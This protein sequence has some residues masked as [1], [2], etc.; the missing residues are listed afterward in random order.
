MVHK[1]NLLWHW[2]LGFRLQW[3]LVLDWYVWEV[4]SHL[5]EILGE[6]AA[7][8]RSQQL[9]RFCIRTQE[10]GIWGTSEASKAF[11]AKPSC[12]I[13]VAT[14][15]F[16]FTDT[17]LGCQWQK[18]FPVFYLVQIL[19]TADGKA[20]IKYLWAWG[21]EKFGNRWQAGKDFAGKAQKEF[22]SNT[23]RM[24][25]FAVAFIPQYNLDD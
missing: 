25:G 9:Q 20:A 3:C 2:V 16:S 21:C 5:R 1:A 10:G 12:L 11:S 15:L 4:P 13:V 8:E 19:K 14:S 24:L 22:A 18:L 23:E 17:S 6:G 7:L